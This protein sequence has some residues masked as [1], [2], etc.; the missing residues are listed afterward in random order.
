MYKLNNTIKYIVFFILFYSPLFALTP[1]I[2]HIKKADD[3][4]TTYSTSMILEK[5]LAKTSISDNN[6][7]K[8][9]DIWLGVIK[10][11]SLKGLC[12]KIRSF[13]NDGFCIKYKNKSIYIIGTNS[14]SLRYGV[15]DFLESMGYRF[16][17][18]DFEVI[19]SKVTINLHKIS[20]TSQARFEYR[21]IF[22]YEA[23]NNDTFAIK[24]R[25]NGHL[26]NLSLKKR[27]KFFIPVFN[28]FPPFALV[29]K[30]YK[31]LFPDYFCGGGLDYALSNVQKIASFSVL[32][33]IKK[34]KIYPGSKIYISHTDG[35]YYCNSALSQKMYK[36]YGSHAAPFLQYT[37]TIASNIAKKYSNIEV[38]MEA[39][40][41]SRKP[42]VSFPVLAKNLGIFFADI[43][44]NFAKPL[45]SNEN[46]ALYNDL[47]NWTKFKR[48][49][50][51]WHYIINFNGYLQPFPDYYAVAKDLKEFEKLKYINGVM[52]EGAYNSPKSAF[53]SMKLWVYSKLLWNPN[54]NVDALIKEFCD[55]YYG[56]ASSNILRYIKLLRKSVM[57]TDSKLLV[58]TS[59]NSP[60]L[61]KTFLNNANKILLDGLK[62][63][64]NNKIYA[65]HV[66]AVLASIEYVMLMQGDISKKGRKYFRAFLKNSKMKYFSEGGRVNELF[67]LLSIHAKKATP[68]FSINIHKEKFLD[69]EE[70][71]FILCCAKIVQ[72]PEAS[73]N[74]AV[75]MNGDSSAWGVQLPLSAL[76]VG[77]WKI[78]ASV[79]IKK[80]NDSIFDDIKPA[81]FYGIYGKDI[82]DGKLIGSLSNGKYHEVEIGVVNIEKGTK[83]TIWIRPP[84]NNAVKYIYVDRIFAV[85]DTSKY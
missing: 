43:E 73:D 68:P 23:N 3:L 71:S 46:I 42:P 7:I 58:K 14:R 52:L 70:N 36:K 55:A 18:A 56:A 65:R 47:K 37:N 20:T 51:V 50:Y 38:F 82:K 16:Y 49:V 79:R 35:D 10:D 83:G 57:K 61:N 81:I 26:G 13:R 21:E 62:K 45:R 11:K 41:W 66:K 27:S 1:L 32:H 15:Y 24:M 17:T 4:K 53:A 84:K 2:Y 12:G 19:P 74:V 60:Y 28:Q 34:L 63:V 64:K 54:L 33:K 30:M 44:A 78:Y 75:R 5:Y 6:G 25:L 69:F 77:R 22:M 67:T 80:A 9:V 31:K 8:S 48:D 40:L 85:K 59:V 72:D 76:P 39:Y 29:P